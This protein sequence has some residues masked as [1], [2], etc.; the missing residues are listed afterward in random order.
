PGPRRRGD[1]GSGWGDLAA[2]QG[3]A[4]HRSWRNRAH[5]RERRRWS[6]GGPRHQLELTDARS[7]A[8]GGTRLSTA[9]DLAQR[10]EEPF[11]STRTA[12]AEAAALLTSDRNTVSAGGGD[13]AVERQHAKGRLTARER[14]AALLDTPAEG[15]ARFDELMA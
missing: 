15:R 2:R 5:H 6:A 3:P 8:G 1:G 10:R 14:I 7:R 11:H 4:R 12:W 13:T 9:I